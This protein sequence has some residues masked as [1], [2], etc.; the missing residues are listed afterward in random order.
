MLED[1]E[2]TFLAVDD[3]LGT[4]KSAASQQR[5]LGAHASCPRIDRVLHVGQFAGRHRARTKRARRA[6]A[7]GGDHLRRR[8]IQHPTRR[9][10]RR[11]R[12]QGSVMPAVFADARPAHFAKTHLDFVG[13]DGGE[14]QILAAQAFAFAQ[15]QRRGDEIARMARIGLPIDVVVIHGADHVAIQK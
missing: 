5:A 4:G 14:N 12:A 3:V 8:E 15:R 11:E 13:D 6:D 1:G 10:R 7:H 2:E 9:D